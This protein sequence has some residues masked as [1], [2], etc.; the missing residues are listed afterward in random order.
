MPFSFE[1]RVRKVILLAY[2]DD[3]ALFGDGDMI[4]NVK[5]GI[6]KHFQITDL[7][8]LTHFLGVSISDLRNGSLTLNQRPLIEKILMDTNMMDAILA[9]HLCRCLISFMRNAS[10]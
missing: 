1:E 7:G 6:K 10:R 3:L 8:K 5:E 4:Q 2:V 9:V